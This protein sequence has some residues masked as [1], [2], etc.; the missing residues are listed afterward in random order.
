M[1]FGT[2]IFYFVLGFALS[3]KSLDISK[4]NL[5]PKK[6]VFFLIT[7]VILTYAIYDSIQLIFSTADTNVA[8]R[9]TRIPVLLYSTSFIISALVYSDLLLKMKKY[10]LKILLYFANISYLVYLIHALMMRI[11]GNFILPNSVFNLIIFTVLVFS[12]SIFFA[13]LSLSAVSLI[14]FH[15]L[16]NVRNF[17]SKNEGF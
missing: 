8:T 15:K 16:K 12:L 14:P 5:K 1:F 4:I 2:W 13:Q 7:L 11:L 17:V 9:S 10:L 3:D 6:L